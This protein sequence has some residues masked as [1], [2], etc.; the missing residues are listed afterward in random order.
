MDM[1]MDVDAEVAVKQSCWPTLKLKRK[2]SSE[3]FMLR[4]S[5]KRKMYEKDVQYKPATGKM[6]PTNACDV[7]MTISVSRKINVLHVT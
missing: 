7:N 1:I 2:R 4:H 5:L 6:W 3:F